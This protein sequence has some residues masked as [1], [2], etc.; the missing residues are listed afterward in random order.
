MGNPLAA[1]RLLRRAIEIG[2]AD[3]SHSTVPPQSLSNMG[4]MLSDL[5]RLEEAKSF[6][7]RASELARQR[8]D[9]VAEV[10]AG[11]LGARVR[12]R[13]GELDDAKR[14]LDAIE[15]KLRTLYP[16]GHPYR[17][18]LESSRGYLLQARGELGAAEES[19]DRALA[20]VEAAPGG[21][22]Y[23]PLILLR[24]SE[25]RLARARPAAAQF[26]AARAVELLRASA[27]QGTRSHWIGR[28]D[29]ALGRALAALEVEDEAAAV[30]RDAV[31]NLEPTL[32]SD[33]PD[34][35]AARALLAEV[36]RPSG[37]NA[38]PQP[39]RSALSADKRGRSRT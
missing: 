29:L 38:V 16:A 34:S 6:A 1:E 19:Q 27:E 15:P 23:F 24:R 13:K 5:G 4:F 26:D 21:L 30:L 20:I 3:P 14:M 31:A 22:P 33:H 11:I 35:R 37:S 32:G 9:D 25:V 17:A 8:G 2:S 18:M 7:G 28:A 10:Q 36:E 12:I 39:A